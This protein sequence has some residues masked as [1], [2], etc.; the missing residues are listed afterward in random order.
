MT[1]R[2]A[3][4]AAF[5]RLPPSVRRALLHRAGRFAPWEEGFDFT[6]PEL[7]PD[8]ETGPPDFV[9]IGAQKAGTTWWYELIVA[10]PGVWA[11]P[12]LHKERHFLARFGQAG[13]G[14]DDA[15]AYRCWFPRRPG[16]I[17]GEWTP[18]YLHWPWVPGLLAVAAPDA[19]LLV[20]LRDPVERF[21]AGVAHQ[22]RN[23][24]PRIAATAADAMARGFYFECLSR[25][26]AHFDQSR[27][28]VL[29]YER[30]AADPRAQM[31]RTYRFLGLD[32]EF[33]PPGLERR[34]SATGAHRF[35]LDEELRRRMV[36]IYL[37]DVNALVR[38]LP[39]LD[40]GLWPNFARV[41]VA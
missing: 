24:A 8:E 39:D 30:C 10:H 13:F 18:D 3:A 14:P 27:M 20:I 2:A 38:H 15:A 19:R 16:T 34:V 6:P 22:W 40:L 5:G 7:G 36:E 4:A 41:G 33:E 25:W 29:Q 32:S 11:R 9:G 28:L 35:V 17:A 37:P 12:D 1:A 23:G 31:A 21:C 26:W